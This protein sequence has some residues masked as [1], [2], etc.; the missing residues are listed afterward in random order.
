MDFVFGHVACGAVLGR[1]PLLHLSSLVGQILDITS[2]AFDF[3]RKS[4]FSSKAKRF[5][6]K[7][8]A[9]DRLHGSSSCQNRTLYNV[10]YVKLLI[11]GCIWL[12]GILQTI[13][14]TKILS[15]T[16]YN[17]IN[18]KVKRGILVTIENSF[19]TTS[20]AWAQMKWQNLHFR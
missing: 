19:A 6:F 17:P 8:C 16:M 10:K 18:H 13:C 20:A 2:I 1:A 15:A 12:K 9:R 5:L 3:T 11:S 7:G 14:P 4:D